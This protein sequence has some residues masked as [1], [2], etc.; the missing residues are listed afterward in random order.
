MLGLGKGGFGCAG[1]KLIEKFEGPIFLS[2]EGAGT[3]KRPRERL[4]GSRSMK[5][6]LPTIRDEK[7]FLWRLEF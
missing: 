5:S 7:S 4:Y 2:G 6:G 3:P 1:W